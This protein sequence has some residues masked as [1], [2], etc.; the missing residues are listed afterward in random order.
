[1]KARLD[2]LRKEIISELCVKRWHDV[3]FFPA[4]EDV[5]GWRGTGPVMFI[6]PNPSRGHFPS[7]ADLF[8]YEQLRH[9][10]FS[11]AHLTDVFKICATSEEMKHHRADRS[12]V[13]LHQSY[14]S[15]EIEIIDP[16]LLVAMTDETLKTLRG[17]LPSSLHTRLTKIHHY[18]WA[19]RYN[20]R[21]EFSKDIKRVRLMRGV[22]NI[23]A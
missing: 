2:Q 9:N 21:E 19:N 15:K 20:R 6:G 1:M 17:W 5:N 4:R 22:A 3:W 13:R 10:G 12:L 11:N 8:F 14:L 16:S 23:G 18:S 7:H